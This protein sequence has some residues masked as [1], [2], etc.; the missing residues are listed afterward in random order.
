MMRDYEG[1]S[2]GV[3][4]DLNERHWECGCVT[5]HTDDELFVFVRVCNFHDYD[6]ADGADIP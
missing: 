4:G 2:Y 5:Y 3:L 1:I 6:E